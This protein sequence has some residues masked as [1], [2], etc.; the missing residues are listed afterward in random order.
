MVPGPA[1]TALDEDASSAY[2]R[3]ARMARTLGSISRSFDGLALSTMHA[4]ASALCRP[5]SASWTTLVLATARLVERAHS[6]RGIVALSANEREALDFFEAIV[7][8]NADLLLGPTPF[9]AAANL[10]PLSHVSA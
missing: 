3:F 2:R 5:S 4:Y 6:L 10:K 8:E 7:R 9:A 1:S